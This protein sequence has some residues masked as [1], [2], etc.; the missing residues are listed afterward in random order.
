MLRRDPRLGS[1]ARVSCLRDNRAVRR[2]FLVFECYRNLCPAVATKA[3]VAV[4][5]SSMVGLSTV[6]PSG[7]VRSVPTIR[8]R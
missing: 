2:L 7:P 1:I 4:S 8:I 5:V 6:V 3:R